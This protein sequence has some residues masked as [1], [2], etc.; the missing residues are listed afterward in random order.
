MTTPSSGSNARGILALALVIACSGCA[1]WPADRAERALYSDLAKA[2]ELSNDTGWVVDRVELD[3]NAE[4]ALRSVC[5]VEPAK[6]ASLDRWLEGQLALAGGPAADI[7]RRHGRDLGAAK[8]A[9]EIERVRALLRYASE[10]AAADCPVWLEPDRDFLGVQGDEGRLVVFA[11]TLGYGSIVL[12]GSDAALGGGGGGRL[13]F[14]SGLGPQL[15]L[16]VG[17]EIGG[18]GAFVENDRGSRTIETTFSAAVPVLLRISRLSRIFDFEVAPTVRF[19]PGVDVFPPGVRGSFALG[20][21]TM[22]SSAFM[23]YALL[24]LAYEYHPSDDRGPA[25]HSLHAGTRVGVDWDP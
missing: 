19:D 7:Y 16:A 2:V 6:R 15:T 25:D 20:F 9:L 10:H 23:P 22:R 5:Q 1:T 17:G 12:E 14:G 13:L 21:S 24:W 18:S 11:D 4:D 3:N 8:D